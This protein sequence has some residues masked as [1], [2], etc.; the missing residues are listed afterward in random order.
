MQN[1]FF[2]AAILLVCMLVAT[3]AQLRGK[4]V[5]ELRNTPIR[6]F[7]KV[8]GK[9]LRELGVEKPRQLKQYK[10]RQLGQVV[11]FFAVRSFFIHPLLVVQQHAITDHCSVFSG[12]R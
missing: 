6:A 8:K 12:L 10:P 4:T 9:T 7:E 1:I 2:N 3:N 5:E 11:K